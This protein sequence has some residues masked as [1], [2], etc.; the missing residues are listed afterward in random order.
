MTRREFIFGFFSSIFFAA[1]SEA[2]EL[3]RTK[4]IPIAEIAKRYGLK[5]TKNVNGKQC[6]CGKHARLSF[7]KNSRSIL[8]NNTKV[9]LGF[10]I[11]L[12]SGKLF[13][14]KRDCMKTIY[15]ILCPC[16][17]IERKKNLRVAIDAG[18][19]GKDF[20]AINKF[21][22]MNEKTLALDIAFRLGRELGKNGIDVVYTRT[23][24]SYTPL[25]NRTAKANKLEADLFVSIHCNA[26]RSSVSGIET[27]ALTPRWTPST[28]ASI[29]TPTDSV[30][31]E[32]NRNDGLNQLL[33]YRIQRELTTNTG[34]VDRGIKCARFAVLRNSKMPSVLV[35][36]GFITNEREATKLGS[37]RYR[38]K[39]ALSI[40]NGIYRYRNS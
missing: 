11:V 26:A 15:P 22:S 6:V 1:H 21:L 4:Y 17:N 32:G 40:A 16:T 30:A 25:T 36:C 10:P 39:L 31:Y 14:A 24:D 35:E 5:S 2:I 20:G 19:G 9:W 8:I 12:N 29:Q 23:K 7:K 3:N 34:A 33:A 37:S 18:H 28:S 38:Q 13:V 27:F